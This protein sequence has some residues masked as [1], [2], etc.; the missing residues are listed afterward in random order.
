MNQFPPVRLPWVLNAHGVEVDAC[1]ALDTDQFDAR[2][3]E[4]IQAVFGYSVFLSQNARETPVA[5]AF[6]ATFVNL[7]ETMQA[8]APSEASACA[9]RLQQIIGVIFPPGED[10]V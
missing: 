3:V 4:F 10:G 5:D 7:L 9:L 1:G 6:L 8:N 2:Q